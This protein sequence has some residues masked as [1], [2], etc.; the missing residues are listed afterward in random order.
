VQITE[1]KFVHSDLKKKR[2][3]RK[4]FVGKKKW[5]IF[6]PISLVLSWSLILLIE[7]NID[8]KK[9]GLVTLKNW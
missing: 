1:S 6:I 9:N 5:L 8:R 4:Q 2:F 7:I 3:S